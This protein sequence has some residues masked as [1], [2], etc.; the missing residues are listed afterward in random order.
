MASTKA[1]Q[2]IC[3]LVKVQLADDGTIRAGKNS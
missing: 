1:Y 3:Q 2:E